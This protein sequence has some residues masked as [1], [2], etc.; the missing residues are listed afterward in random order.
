MTSYTVHRTLPASGWAEN[1][2]GVGNNLAE[3]AKPET[4]GSGAFGGVLS[5]PVEWV[6]A[7]TLASLACGVLLGVLSVKLAAGPR[8]RPGPEDTEGTGS[9]EITGYCEDPRGSDS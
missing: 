8:R 2:G 6:F 5:T 9:R 3:L 1:G 7:S 4:A